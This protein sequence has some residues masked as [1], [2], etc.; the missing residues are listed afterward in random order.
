MRR[1]RYKSDIACSYTI[2][3]KEQCWHDPCRSAWL[4]CRNSGNSTLCESTSPTG[5]DFTPWTVTI[6]TREFSHATHIKSIM[7]LFM[8]GFQSTFTGLNDTSLGL[9]LCS[10]ILS[11]NLVNI[12]VLYQMARILN[13]FWCK[14]VHYRLN[15]CVLPALHVYDREETRILTEL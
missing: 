14:Y 5:T 1:I 9:G 2:P 4:P 10:S 7:F 13:H 11:S 15:M 3:D 6:C 12:K 8:A